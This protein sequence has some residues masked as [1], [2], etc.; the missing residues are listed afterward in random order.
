MSLFISN[1]SFAIIVFEMGLRT[2]FQ[3]ST[4]EKNILEKEQMIYK[5][6][7]VVC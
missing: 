3:T 1:L 7:F 4:L 2:T 6:V 5:L